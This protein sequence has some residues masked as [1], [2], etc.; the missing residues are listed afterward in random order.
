MVPLLFQRG[1]GDTIVSAHYGAHRLTG[2]DAVLRAD[3]ANRPDELLHHSEVAD[4]SWIMRSAS[5]LGQGATEIEAVAGRPGKPQGSA[6]ARAEGER[7]FVM[8]MCDDSSERAIVRSTVDLGHSLGLRVVAEG[9]EDL[10]TWR[11]LEEIGCDLLQ[12]YYIAKPMPAD[13]FVPWL[14]DQRFADR[15]PVGATWI[16][17][18]AQSTRLTNEG[19]TCVCDDQPCVIELGRRELER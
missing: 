10:L 12:G 3:R 9:V 6:G 19:R 15:T 11:A 5:C 8:T 17:T 18:A 7:S 4:C 13:Q 14:L 1:R 2:G 16:I